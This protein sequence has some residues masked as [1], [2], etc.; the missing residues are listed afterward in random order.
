MR[1]TTL[2]KKLMLLVVVVLMGGG[3]A[4]AEDI[5]TATF[6]GKNETYTTGWTTTGTG[7]GRTDCIIIGSDEN[8]TSPAFNLSAYNEV[9]ISIKARRY[10]TLTGSK[11]TIDVSIGG[12]SVGTTDAKSTS[13]TT[14]LDDIIFTPTGSMTA[15]V[16]VFT[17][18]NATSAG[19]SHGAGINTITITGTKASNPN[20]KA[21]I[22]TIDPTGITNTDVC[23]GTDAGTLTATVT[24]DGGTALSNPSITW[25]SSNV[26]VA[27]IDA[28]GSVTLVA[29][30]STTIT[31]SYA[32]ES[33]VYGSSSSTY[34]LTVTDSTP[35]TGA[36]VLTNLAELTENDIFVIVG[37]NGDNYAMS[38]NNGTGSAPKVVAVTIAND[39]ITDVTDNI[40][41]NIGGNA[42]DGYTFY[43][44]GSTE[45]WLYCNTTANSSSNNNMRVGTGDRKVFVL[46]ND[47]HLVTNDD[48]TD[49]YISIYNDQDW[50][51][52]VN[53]NL[54]PSISFYKYV[55]NSG[56]QTPHISANAVDLTYDATSGSIAFTVTNAVEGGVMSAS[57][58]ANW[59]TLGQETVSP[60]SFTCTANDAS[61]ERTATVTLTYTYNTNE[62]VTKDVTITQAAAPVIY[63]TI[64]ALF[65][66]ATSTATDVT[67]TFDSWVV[68]A[69]KDSNAYLTDNQGNGLIIYAS[70]HGFQVNDVLTGTVSCKLQLYRG[71]AE[72]TSLTSTTTGL[73]V[74]PNGSVNEKNIA[75]SELS[76]VN[77][78][79]LLAYEGLTYNGTALVDGNNNTITPY[80]TLYS[81]TFESD[82]TYNVK[83]I[84]LQYNTTKEIL[85]RSADDIEEVTA[86][87][88]EYTLT[89]T[90]S[91]NVE[92]F[93]FVGDLNNQ[94]VEGA[95][96]QQVSN[97]TE[98]SLSVSATQGYTLK[99]LVD[100][101]DVTS[102]IDDSGLYT[103]TMPAHDVTVTATAVA[104]E[105]PVDPAVAGVGAFV[106]VTSTAD[107]TS[108]NYLIVYE[109]GGV[110][111][112]G[113]LETLDAAKNTIGVVISNNMIASSKA[114]V[115]ATFIVQPNSGT[116]QS[117][118][119]Y[120]IGHQGR[121][122][123]LKQSLESIYTNTFEIDNEGNANIACNESYLKFN[124]TSDQERFRYYSNGQEAIQLYKYDPTATPL[125]A[126]AV[127]KITDA[128]YATYCSEDVLNFD[129]VEGLTAYKAT[130]TSENAI[131]TPVT[132]VPA[133]EGIL[134][135]GAKG[136]YEIPVI[137]STNA[138][139]TGNAFIG[140]LDATEVSDPI[141]VLMNGNDGVGFYKT[142]QTF[143]VGAHTAY[144]PA[145]AGGNGARSFIGFDFDNTVTAIEG[146]ADVKGHNGEVYNLQSQRV[147]KAQKGLYIINGKKMVIK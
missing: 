58:D 4:W 101:T 59:L 87:A 112:N 54:A 7:K 11:A 88:V 107:I 145:S 138:D 63:T 31:A 44:Y 5:A 108:G 65:T 17:C 57:T 50:R 13:A 94:G 22:L 82:K 33:G 129:A 18:T 106:K 97:G 10:G 21:T 127:V 80:S 61:T 83:G 53:A 98:V 40:K 52:Y 8:I 23:A 68:S 12:T 47:N 102:Q 26:G 34:E 143:T 147:A 91:E 90:A 111:L 15:A 25:S 55:D 1:Q 96:T 27:T 133:E 79:A 86:P 137:E 29:A 113:G 78:G 136:R 95:T 104:P 43:P 110:A 134:L 39:E 141:F 35:K 89:V 16:L 100:G 2:L 92:I 124:K 139:F 38:N 144:L 117:K 73:T 116:I 109:D 62:T 30:G 37:N 6:N 3:S 75:I 114:T 118:S 93:T 67:I 120:Y 84:Y 41:W 121:N 69:V 60:I 28:D 128:G 103:F 130:I 32:G 123:A 72:L 140:V 24:P 77:T 56:V 42:T 19:S 14:Q 85:P 71:S 105:V 125:P 70:N 74:T 66:D 146:V 81:S 51:G 36:W 126:Y 132:E 99:L 135:K 122:N 142:T 76:G 20:E 131:F 49:R 46:N 115:A 9:T 119:G 45:T 48:Y 64:P